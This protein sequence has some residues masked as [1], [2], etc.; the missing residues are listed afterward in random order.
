MLFSPGAN[1][2]ETPWSTD[3]AGTIK[4]LI[5]PEPVVAMHLDPQ[6]VD[7]AESKVR[8]NFPA[9]IVFRIAGETVE[10]P[11]RGSGSSA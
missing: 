8:K 6:A 4:R 3:G 1:L 7:E 2:Y 10:L 9:A 11:A 5:R